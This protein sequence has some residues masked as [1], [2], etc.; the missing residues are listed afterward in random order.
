MCKEPSKFK[1]QADDNFFASISAHVSIVVTKSK[2]SRE[3]LDEGGNCSKSEIYEP[4]IPV[5]CESRVWNEIEVSAKD[6][7][8]D[9]LVKEMKD[10][11]K[12]TT[13]VDI[14]S[15]EGSELESAPNGN[16]VVTQESKESKTGAVATAELSVLMENDATNDRTCGRRRTW[17]SRM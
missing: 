8:L 17:W 15:D 5:Q 9:I 14:S 3:A 7:D 13:V 10:T 11:C 2:S 12:F 4:V 6:E 16:L 1:F